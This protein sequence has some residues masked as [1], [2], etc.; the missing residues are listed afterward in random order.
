MT[1]YMFFLQQ[2]L[3]STSSSRMSVST[4]LVN[5]SAQQ[6]YDGYSE[7]YALSYQKKI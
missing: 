4:E 3:R 1:N 2:R 5:G 7:R 6:T